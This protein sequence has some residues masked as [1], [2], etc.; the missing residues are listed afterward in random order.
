MVGEQQEPDEN[1]AG[2]KGT[3]EMVFVMCGEKS[4]KHLEVEKER[5]RGVVP[6]RVRP[7]ILKGLFNVLCQGSF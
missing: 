4:N 3:A 6:I 5:K 7:S 2:I 1:R